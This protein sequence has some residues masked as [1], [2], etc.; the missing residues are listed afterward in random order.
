M[1]GW[2]LCGNFW[3]ASS[4]HKIDSYS[5]VGLCAIPDDVG[6]AGC[7][8]TLGADGKIQAWRSPR[9]ELIDLEDLAESTDSKKTSAER[10]IKKAKKKGGAD[11]VQSL[12]AVSGGGDAK[13][14][15]EREKLQ[16]QRDQS[17]RKNQLE[18][19]P[20]ES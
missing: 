11:L 18:Q 4:S 8:V 7:G 10:L 5:K 19:S 16:F 12:L 13:L 9:E 15:L 2:S 1:R 20:L 3:S 17:E 14:E 6:A